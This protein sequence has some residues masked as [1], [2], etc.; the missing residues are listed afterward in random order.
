[1]HRKAL[2]KLLDRYESL[3]PGEAAMVARIRE[4]VATHTDCF[5][6]TCLPGHITGS[7]WI[8]SQDGAR[9]LLVHH[10]KLGRWLQP[11]GHADG[12]TDVAAAALREAIEETG[13]TSLRFAEDL[14]DGPLP[15][16]ID[17]HIIPERRTPTGD[18]IDRAHEHHD[19]RFL[20]VAARDD[21]ILVSDESHDVRWFTP[22]EIEQLDTDES[23]RRMLRKV[24]QKSGKRKAE[25]GD[26]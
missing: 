3:H 7:A 6:R 1:M 9:H 23:V 15:L 19:I 5:E 20:F 25:S 22:G 16:D 24:E 10:R 4:L 2:L 18:L 17:V 21:A 26:A 14:P 8:V 13:L 12:Q 11:G